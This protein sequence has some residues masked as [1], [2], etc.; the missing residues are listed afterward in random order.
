MVNLQQTDAADWQSSTFSSPVIY[1]FFP[2]VLKGT[3][4]AAAVLTKCDSGEAPWCYTPL[5]A[6]I[7]SVGTRHCHSFEQNADHTHRHTGTETTV[8]VCG[9]QPV[10]ETPAGKYNLLGRSLCKCRLDENA[11]SASH[12]ETSSVSTLEHKHRDTPGGTSNTHARNTSVSYAV[13]NW[14]AMGVTRCAANNKFGKLL[15]FFQTSV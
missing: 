4:G 13:H 12:L 6:A 15:F 9:S 3:S 5:I 7:H 14:N 1:F 2:D 10:P 11:S 8:Q